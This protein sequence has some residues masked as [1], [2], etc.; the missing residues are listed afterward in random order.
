M[1]ACRE[2]EKVWRVA[3]TSEALPDCVGPYRTHCLIANDGHG[4][5]EA[6]GAQ[7]QAKAAQATFCDEH[8]VKAPRVVDTEHALLHS[9]CISGDGDHALC[10]R[11]RGEL[12]CVELVRDLI[13]MPFPLGKQLLHPLLPVALCKEG[14][15]LISLQAR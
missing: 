1:F 9:F 13:V 11:F 12:A 7:V 14:S 8:R 3:S 10:H 5:A 15:H 6:T 4:R 2:H